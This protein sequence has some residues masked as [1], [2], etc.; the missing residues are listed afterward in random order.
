MLMRRSETSVEYN[1]S[2][3]VLQTICIKILPTT[4]FVKGVFFSASKGIFLLNA[5]WDDLCLARRHQRLCCIPWSEQ[6]KSQP[7][8]TMYT[9]WFLPQSWRYLYLCM[10]KSMASFMPWNPPSKQL[11]QM[12]AGFVYENHK[13]RFRFFKVIIS[14]K[15]LGL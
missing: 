11:S 12:K 4:C 13:H 2:L 1:D 5:N 10:A 9:G 7:M 3:E 14:M 15:H 8:S 6:W